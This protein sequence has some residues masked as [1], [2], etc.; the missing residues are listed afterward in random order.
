MG[1]MCDSEYAPSP[2]SNVD[3]SYITIR[4]SDEKPQE[5]SPRFRGLK[6]ALK[7]EAVALTSISDTRSNETPKKV[8]KSVFKNYLVA[9][10]LMKYHPGISAQFVLRWCVLTPEKFKYYKSH[11]SATLGEKPLL[12]ISIALIQTVER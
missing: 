9:G 4:F 12:S 1:C 7:S 5:L 3:C 8:Y 10:N 6:K 11:Y 2:D